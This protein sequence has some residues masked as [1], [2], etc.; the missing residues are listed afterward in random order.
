M[1][2]K[3]RR[4]E[5]AGAMFLAGYNC[6]QATAVPFGDLVGMD[7]K[8]L[9][10]ASAAFGGGV[11]K[12]KEVCGVVSGM[13]LIYGL[14]QDDKTDL[15]VKEEKDKLYANGQVLVKKFSDKHNTINCGVLL[16]VFEDNPS[17]QERYKEKPCLKLVED[18]AAILCDYF[19]I[20]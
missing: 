2:E 1:T 20:V 7:E 3:E 19:G 6:A 10:K 12:L 16:K 18:G 9:I 4:I 5:K 17:P 13:M 8:M 14:S 11:S 15:S